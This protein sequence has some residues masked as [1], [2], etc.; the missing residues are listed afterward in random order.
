MSTSTK[1]VIC[2]GELFNVL[3]GVESVT[4]MF[5]RS[6]MYA[7]FE[8]ADAAGGFNIG[9]EVLV[10]LK[11]NLSPLNYVFADIF[12]SSCRRTM[13]LAGLAG[14]IRTVPF[15]GSSSKNSTPSAWV[16]PRPR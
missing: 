11:L 9:S 6:D 12:F 1:S 5:W 16:T 13:P 3:K 8:E 4:P 15:V 2:A 10:T 7:N 14:A